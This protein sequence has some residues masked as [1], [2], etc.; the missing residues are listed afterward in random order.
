M[1]RNKSIRL[2]SAAAILSF[3]ATLPAS[4]EDEPSRGEQELAKI[5]EG[6]VAGEP[7]KCLHSSQSDRMQVVPDTAFVFRDGRTIYVNRPRGAEV[8]DRSDLP[9]FRQFGSQLCRLDQVELRDR[10]SGFPG[11]VIVLE[12]FVPYTKV[13]EDN[14]KG[15]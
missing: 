14:D 7:I 11:P 6:R 9:V 8:L 5:L 4:A 1:K 13:A 10:I 12:D 15:G 2:A 3:C